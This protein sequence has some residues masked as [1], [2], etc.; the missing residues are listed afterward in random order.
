MAHLCFSHLCMVNGISTDN[1]KP[2]KGIKQGDSPS[3]SLFLLMV[4]LSKLIV[5]AT[6][7]G[8][9]HDFQVVEN[10]IENFHLQFVD[11][12][13]IFV[14][15]NVEDVKKLLLILM[16]FELLT[17]M[18]LNLEKNSMISVGADDVVRGMAMELG[19]KVEKL[20]IKYLSLPLGASY[21]NIS[22][23]NEVIQRMEVKL[24]NWRK[25]N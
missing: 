7:R 15:A 18:K 3:L 20:P 21:R 14:D 11:D 12:I 23:W 5:D 1:F 9:L 10:E 6:S 16:T 25:K 19:C 22:V 8:Q 4:V 24:S 13:L 2:S 17:G